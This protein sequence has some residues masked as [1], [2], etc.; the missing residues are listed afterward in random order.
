MDTFQL[1][2]TYTQSTLSVMNTEKPGPEKA[3]KNKGR[4]SKTRKHSLQLS[5]QKTP[6][7]ITPIL[8]NA[9]LLSSA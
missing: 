2:S 5:H 4:S 7:L 3:N 9:S 8:S 1:N 6:T